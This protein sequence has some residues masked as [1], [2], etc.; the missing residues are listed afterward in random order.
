M[1]PRR[2]TTA[3]ATA[4]GEQAHRN[5]AHTEPPIPSDN[6]TNDA[7]ARARL[8]DTRAELRIPLPGLNRI[9]APRLLWYGGLG[10]L[11]TIGILDWPVALVVGA[12]TL[13]AARARGA[14]TNAGQPPTRPAEGQR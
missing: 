10:A 4:T 12:G 6:T 14:T 2:R 5:G 1:P 11:A 9:D 13:I 7:P 3:G 8:S